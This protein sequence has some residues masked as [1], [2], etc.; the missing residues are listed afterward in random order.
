MSYFSKKQILTGELK[1][2]WLFWDWEG[3]D[4]LW[5]FGGL[6]LKNA[7]GDIRGLKVEVGDSDGF[8]PLIFASLLWSASSACSK[9]DGFLLVEE[10]FCE[11]WGHQQVW[12]L[13]FGYMVSTREAFHQLIE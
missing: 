8:L 5:W 10:R 1:D 6:W 4:K 12:I 13:F 2:D 11:P 9:N 7:T 3:I